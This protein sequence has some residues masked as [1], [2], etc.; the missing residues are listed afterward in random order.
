MTAIRAVE[1]H[2]TSRLTEIGQ[3]TALAY[4]ADQLVDET[5]DYVPELKDAA[6]RAS[7][8]T[9]L[10]MFGGDGDGSVLGSITIAPHGTPLA[11]VANEEGDVELR[12]LAVSPLERGRG[13]GA[14]L[15]KA[16]MDFAV[17]ELGA[18]RVVLST[19]QEMKVAHRI[20]ERLGFERDESLD[21]YYDGEGPFLGYVW[22]P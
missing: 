7:E 13:V 3:L 8:G 4:L 16:A 11:E 21:W 10:A 1:P 9:L 20:Y 2:E 17:D 5:D 19:M 18:K 14:E 15:A 22:T 12:M 6:R